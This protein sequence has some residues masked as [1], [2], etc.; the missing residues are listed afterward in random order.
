MLKVA[1]VVT[2]CACETTGIAGSANN[3]DI[4]LVRLIGRMGNSFHSLALACRLC[5]PRCWND[6]PFAS[7][8]RNARSARTTD[9][10]GFVHSPTLG[11]K[12][13]HLAHRDRRS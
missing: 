5:G 6:L 10:E 4:I 7:G 1:R 11:V 2:V 8:S 12:M 13:Q 3:R 9:K